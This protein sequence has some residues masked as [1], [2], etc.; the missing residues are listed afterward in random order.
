LLD[1]HDT[2]FGMKRAFHGILRIT[3][4]P[5]AT[6]GLTPARFDML[7][8]LYARMDH[9]ALQSAI[10]RVLGV[11]APT[12]SR[13]LGSLEKLGLIKRMRFELD[14]RERVVALTEGGLRCM[15]SAHDAFVASG[16][17]QLALDCALAFPTQ[18]DKRRCGR[19]V[20]LLDRLVGRMR[21]QFGDTATLAYHRL[22]EW[23]VMGAPRAR[24][25]HIP[26][27]YRVFW[28]STPP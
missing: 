6:R 20:R 26:I 3:R 17:A 25:L 13:M 10:R 12:V 5:L 18:H 19:I 9:S 2:F 4:R 16:A 1:V 11:T 7:Y 15:Q 28:G 23:L 8:V 14:K 22:P 21:L 27:M 24:V